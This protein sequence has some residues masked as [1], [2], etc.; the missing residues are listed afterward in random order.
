MLALTLQSAKNIA[1]AIVV[2]LILVSLIVARVMASV[3]KRIIV[4]VVLVALAVLVWTQRQSLETCADKVRV[5]SGEATCTF[6]GSN[7]TI[8]APLPDAPTGG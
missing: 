1:I 4:V 6:F 8:N 7:V 3:T 2:G 5:G